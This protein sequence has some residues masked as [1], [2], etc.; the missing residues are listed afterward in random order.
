MGIGL[1]TDSFIGRDPSQRTLRP[2]LRTVHHLH[3]ARPYPPQNH[4]LPHLPQPRT[5]LNLTPIPPLRILR[6][7]PQDFRRRTR[8][9]PNHVVQ[10]NGVSLLTPHVD[11]AAQDQVGGVWRDIREGV[12]GVYEAPVLGW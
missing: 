7:A 8:S 6:S 11:F 5:R 2:I 3:R 1:T 12:V 10:I 4:P 9:R